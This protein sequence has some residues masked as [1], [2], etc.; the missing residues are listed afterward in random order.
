[1]PVCYIYIIPE[2]V[3]AR[4][5]L[6][7]LVYIAKKISSQHF[8]GEEVEPGNP[9]PLNTALSM[10]LSVC[11]SHHLPA[12]R[13]CGGFAADRRAGRRYRSTAATAGLSAA[14]FEQC[15]VVS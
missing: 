1:M 5:S 11:P 13:P 6:G 9:P 7:M 8:G 12:A 4:T 10:N 2:C 15:H 14:K 3:S